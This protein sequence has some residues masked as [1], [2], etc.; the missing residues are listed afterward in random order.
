[1]GKTKNQKVY[2]IIQGIAI[3]CVFVSLGLFVAMIF[4]VIP[5]SAGVFA[6]VLIIGIISGS[7]MTVLPWVRQYSKKEFTIL[8][9][10]MFGLSAVSCILWIADAIVAVQ[11]AD[12]VKANNTAKYV[13]QLKFLRTSLILTFQIIVANAVSACVVKYRKSMIPFQVITYLSHLYIDLYGTILL[14]SISINNSGLNLKGANGFLS[15]KIA[16]MF[17][18]LALA[19][20]GVSNAIIQRMDRRRHRDALA[21]VTEQEV[22]ADPS[23]VDYGNAS[24]EEVFGYS[25]YTEQKPAAERSVQERLRELDDLFSGNLISAEEYEQKR[26]EIMKDL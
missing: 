14:A 24:T 21:P 13:G 16:I 12:A 18:V 7:C 6:L 4:D 25:D 9:Y 26:A 17:A 8:C 3:A 11:I 22:P 20:V 2:G 10:V 1:M 23:P 15:N 5:Y 19:Y